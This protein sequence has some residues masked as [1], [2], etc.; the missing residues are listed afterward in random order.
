MESEAT[1][2]RHQYAD[3]GTLERTS[4]SLMHLVRLRIKILYVFPLQ[5]PA[6]PLCCHGSQTRTPWWVCHHEDGWHHLAF[7]DLVDV[8]GSQLRYPIT[9]HMNNV[10]W[11]HSK[12]ANQV[13][14][15]KLKA[16][17]LDMFQ[18][19]Y[20]TDWNGSTCQHLRTSRWSTLRS[21][22]RPNLGK[23]LTQHLQ[24]VQ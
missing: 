11:P 3:T 17:P 7:L 2:L 23:F 13:S 15:P 19:Q 12:C 14:H 22:I 18:P 16:H 20:P 4:L 5:A 6:A 9:S 24:G 1:M 10:H 8:D 21:L